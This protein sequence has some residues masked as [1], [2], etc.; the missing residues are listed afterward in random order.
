MNPF[1]AHQDGTD[2][3]PGS[4]CHVRKLFAVLWIGS[5]G[6]HLHL[7]SIHPPLPQLL[8]APDRQG[9][10]PLRSGSSERGLHPWLRLELVHIGMRAWV[11]YGGKSRLH[12]LWETL[13]TYLPP[14]SSPMRWLLSSWKGLVPFARVIITIFSVLG[15]SLVGWV[16]GAC[17]AVRWVMRYVCDCGFIFFRSCNQHERRC[18]CVW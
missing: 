3:T 16:I 14:L 15:F 2:Q 18:Q 8:R 10:D 1:H 6:K 17:V 9:W 12:I 11:S 4:I 13:C 5:F 7:R